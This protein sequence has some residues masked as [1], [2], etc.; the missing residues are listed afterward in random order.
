[1]YRN[2]L[3]LLAEKEYTR[4]LQETLNK[5]EGYENSI[6]V[7]VLPYFDSR[8]KNTGEIVRSV[9]HSTNLYMIKVMSL[10]Y[11]EA[12]NPI[13]KDTVIFGPPTGSSIFLS[14]KYK[15]GEN[16][17]GQI[18]TKYTFGKGN[19]RDIMLGIGTEIP[20]VN[21]EGEVIYQKMFWDPNPD[22]RDEPVPLIGNINE[23]L[24]AK[25]AA[26]IKRR[27]A[28]EKEEAQYWARNDNYNDYEKEAEDFNR[29]MDIETD[30]FWRDL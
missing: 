13:F 22:T 26:I 27:E 14:S 8:G 12:A 6:G 24:K 4:K 3:W 30:G 1:M 21:E 5:S 29:Q 7:F 2:S 15:A 20:A 17:G 18:V 9:S 25:D 19:D 16:I 23:I 11:D 28:K 10:Y